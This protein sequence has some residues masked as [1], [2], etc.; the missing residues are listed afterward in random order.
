MA[1]N[2]GPALKT[3]EIGNALLCKTLE[4]KHCSNDHGS[5]RLRRGASR[6]RALTLI[7]C[8]RWMSLLTAKK[9]QAVQDLD[10]LKGGHDG[11]TV[12]LII[13]FTDRDRGPI[14]GAKKGRAPETTKLDVIKGAHI[15]FRSIAARPGDDPDIAYISPN[16]PISGTS[17]RTLA[18]LRKSV[19]AKLASAQWRL[20]GTGVGVPLLTARTHLA[21]L[22]GGI[23]RIRP[24]VPRVVYSQS[25]GSAQRYFG[26]IRP[27]NAVG[28]NH[29]KEGWCVHKAELFPNSKGLR[30]T[31]H[32]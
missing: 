6:I 25:W 2:G 21:I 11:A 14:E 4:T 19:T 16:R 23:R 5:T 20:D 17:R 28:R 31:K 26:P 13:Q 27:R 30:R 7:T 12:M 32:H 22:Y 24:T 18:T 8:G 1:P 29:W 10:A 15:P 9:H 3:Q